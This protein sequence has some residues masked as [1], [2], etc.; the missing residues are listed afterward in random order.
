M[1]EFVDRRGG[2]LLW[3]GGHSSLADGVWGGSSLV[4]LLPVVLPT[5]KN[6][7][8][9]APATAELTAAGADSLICRLADDPDVNAQRWKKLPYMMD[10][11]E[12]GTPKPG[13]AVL[14]EM[15][16]GSNKTADAHHP[17]LWPRPNRRPG[18]FRY[19]AMADEHAAG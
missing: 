5:H 9:R 12:A 3:L 18:H 6:T 8:H 19:L 2:G 17:E 4:D 13:A 11:Q 14:A 10:Y 16:A 7:F 1:R 15:R